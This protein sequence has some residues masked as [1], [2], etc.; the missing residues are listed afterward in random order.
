MK[1]THFKV[2]SLHQVIVLHWSMLAAWVLEVQEAKSCLLVMSGNGNG[3]SEFSHG[4]KEKAEGS[5]D[6]Q[7][8]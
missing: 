3:K 4:C 5:K 2:C 1:V 7:P 6:G 8:I